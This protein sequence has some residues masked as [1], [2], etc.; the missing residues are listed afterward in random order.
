MTSTKSHRTSTLAVLAY[1]LIGLLIASSLTSCTDASVS[2]I[3]SLG[4]A[5]TISMVNCDGSITHTFTS[6]GKVASS[7]HSDGYYFTDAATGSLT[8]VSGNVIITRVNH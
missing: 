4:D 5:H 7:T 3:T 2:R 1:M 8:E 6:T